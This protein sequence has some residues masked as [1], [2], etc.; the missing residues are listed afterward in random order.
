MAK[1]AADALT[2]AALSAPTPCGA[3]HIRIAEPT[4][5]GTTTEGRRW[6][7]LDIEILF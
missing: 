7:A 3:A 1:D 6:Y 5:P 2:A 4:G